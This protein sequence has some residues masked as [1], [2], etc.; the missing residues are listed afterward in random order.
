MISVRNLA[1]LR[2]IIEDFIATNEPVASKSLVER[3]NFG[4]SSATI[5]NDM[6]ALEE[7][8][9][10]TAPH[11]SSGRIPTDKGYRVFVD[12][13][14]QAEAESVE[15]RKN[16]SELRKLFSKTLD[17]LTDL[18]ERLETSAQMLAKA[19]GEAAVIQYPNLNSVLVR[20]IELVKVSSNRALVI[21]ITESE[22]IQQHLVVFP[23]DVTDDQL[24]Q[25]RGKVNSVAVGVLIDDLPA[26]LKKTL[27]AVA[28]A[29]K[30]VL[31][32]IVDGV[33][34]LIDSNRQ[35]KLAYAGTTNLVRNEDQ[36][37]GGLP[38]LL[39]TLDEQKDLF[40]F[41]NNW[42][43]DSTQPRAIIG[44]ENSVVELTNSSLLLSSYHNQGEE[45]AKV[46][47]VGPTRM[48]YSKN[49]AAV[50]ALAHL[51]SKDIEE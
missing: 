39:E 26:L 8:G 40:A 34:L 1:V 18:D 49:L 27:E 24:Q 51:L 12:Q 23:V 43:L 37:G 14:I 36:F 32:R 21:L 7:E 19:T 42:K 35:D 16:F 11:T 10:I 22:R 2:A 44:S 30:A 6:A 33:L 20:A 13:L 48:N 47:L 4:V 38:S 9:Y 41:L 17:Q 45:V 25:L 28:P 29:D 50:L 31:Q 3:H 5:R 15:I 46:A